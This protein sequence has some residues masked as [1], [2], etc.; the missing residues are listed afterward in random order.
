MDVTGHIDDSKSAA[1]I[2]AH[3]S[4]LSTMVVGI[5]R[6]PI[7]LSGRPHVRKVLNLLSHN[8]KMGPYTKV[9]SDIMA[10]PGFKAKAKL[11]AGRHLML[12]MPL[13][14]LAIADAESNKHN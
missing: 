10:Q 4:H 13:V 12:T 1:V 7:L 2:E 14:P 3:P 8:S 9:V 11:V 6:S 5:R